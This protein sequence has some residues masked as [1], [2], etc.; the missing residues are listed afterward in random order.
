MNILYIAQYYPAPS[1]AGSMRAWEQTTRLSRAGHKVTVVT[2]GPHDTREEHDGVVVIRVASAYSNELSPAR[3]MVSFA[4]F[5]ARSIGVTLRQG[6]DV[7]FATSTPLTTAIP[8]LLAN[9]VRGTPFIFEVRDLWPS[10][11][12]ALGYLKNPLVIALAQALERAAYSRATHVVALSPGMAEGVHEVANGTP[13]TVIPNAAD[14][15][16]FAVSD[17]DVARFRQEKGW[18]QDFIVVYAGSF[19]QTYELE[20][21]VRI[22]AELQGSGV[23][24]VLLG[25]GSLTERLRDLA[26]E[27]GLPVEDLLPGAVAK[28]EV[29]R[30]LTA[31]D[32]VLSSI[33]NVPALHVNSLNKVFDAFAAG[34]PIFFTHDGWLSE[35]CQSA[36]A[37]FRL[38]SLDPAQAARSLTTI[39]MDDTLV[40]AAGKKSAELG[41][42]DFSRD[43]L[44]ATLLPLFENLD[45]S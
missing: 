31:A 20:H 35:M 21:V 3:R 40:E 16:R 38:D 37:G 6:S 18:G 36:G 17:A 27:L 26:V 14:F 41:R 44:F 19:G 10:A 34:K 23:R 33:R 13:V 28:E 12:I 42:A 1:E 24:F 25:Q 29:V 22:A 30:H 45:K 11:P 8:A 7:I 39:A 4:R 32:A 2:G 5:A 9:A 15:D 43:A